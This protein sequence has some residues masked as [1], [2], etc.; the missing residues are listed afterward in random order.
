MQNNNRRYHPKSSQAYSDLACLKSVHQSLWEQAAHVVFNKSKV[1]LWSI[2]QVCST[3]LRSGDWPGHGRTSMRASLWVRVTTLAVCGR[4]FPCIS[5]NESPNRFRNGLKQSS[6]HDLMIEV[7]LDPNEIGSSTDLN[8]SPIHYCSNVLL[9]PEV[10]QT[11]VRLVSGLIPKRVAI[12]FFKQIYLVFSS[13]SSKVALWHALL[14]LLSQIPNTL[15]IAVKFKR[16]YLSSGGRWF[17]SVYEITPVWAT[18]TREMNPTSL[19]I[20]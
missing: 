2:S 1:F 16:T 18:H 5:R 13:T 11:R 10:F 17:T 4:S 3:G 8:T 12:V 6:P 7:P 9:S 15:V 14:N 20:D 19:T